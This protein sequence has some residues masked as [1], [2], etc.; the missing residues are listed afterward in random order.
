[1]IENQDTF[2]IFLIIKGM[3]PYFYGIVRKVKKEEYCSSR[4]GSKNPS[5]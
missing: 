1:M 2:M 4:R 3:K 5:I